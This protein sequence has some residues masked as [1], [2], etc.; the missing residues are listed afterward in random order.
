MWSKRQVLQLAAL[1]SIGLLSLT[2]HNWRRTRLEGSLASP[3]Q[4]TDPVKQAN[5]MV[6]RRL[7]RTGL[8]VSEVGFGSWGIGGKAYGGVSR[9]EAKDAMARA[10]ELGCNL[11]DTAQVY[12]DSEAVLGE[13][14]VGRRIKWNIATKYSG[15]APSLTAVLEQQLRTLR[16]DYVDLYQLHWVPGDE[17]GALYDELRRAKR[18]GKVRFVGVSASTVSSIAYALN[19]PDIDVIQ[20]PLNLLQP[21]PFLKSLQGIR[22][23]NVGVIVRSSLREGF[24]TGKYGYGTRFTDPND[25]RSQLSSDKIET[26]LDQVERNRQHDVG[27]H[28][29]PAVVSGGLYGCTGD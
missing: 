4:S 15:Q 22:E 13:F 17:G 3:E 10:E 5:G 12:G 9:Q 14:M 18:A 20:I 24:L 6:Y 25:R 11:V 29:L 26:I 1:S 16:T 8:L 21:N 19:Q 7:G 23:R 27:G 2:G 28:R